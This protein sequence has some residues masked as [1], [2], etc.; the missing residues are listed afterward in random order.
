MNE[1]IKLVG[2]RTRER[3]REIEIVSIYFC[4]YFSLGNIFHCCYLCFFFLILFCRYYACALLKLLI[5]FTFILRELISIRKFKKR[6]KRKCS[7]SKKKKNWEYI[8]HIVDTIEIALEII[9]IFRQ[10]RSYTF[11]YREIHRVCVCT[12]KALLTFFGLCMFH[13]ICRQHV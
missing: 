13:I 2:E 4:W 1:Q 12:T 8:R 5:A 3:E 6:Y 10:L 9:Q 7:E 11:Q